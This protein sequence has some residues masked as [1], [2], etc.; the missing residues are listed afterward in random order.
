MK[1]AAIAL[2]LV[3][4]TPVFASAASFQMRRDDYGR[5]LY[6]SGNIVEGD[7][8]RLHNAV[9]RNRPAFLRVSSNGGDAGESLRL[10]D[11]LGK[12]RI[13]TRILG[14]DYCISACAIMIMGAPSRQMS[15]KAFLG[16]HAPYFNVQKTLR[17]AG[18]PGASVG[19]SAKSAFRKKLYGLAIRNRISQRYVD[20]MLS[21]DNPRGYYRM[22]AQEAMQYGL[23]PRVLPR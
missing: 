2:M 22:T 8:A 19:A 15:P 20:K 17:A 4:L 12:N 5:Y 1:S 9:K 3:L 14:A 21:F 13:E 11:Y 7:V 18:V 10:A 6:M 16:L 23:I